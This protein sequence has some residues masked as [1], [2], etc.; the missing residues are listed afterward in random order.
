MKLT[1]VSPIPVLVGMEKSERG[2]Q[3][4]AAPWC[5]TGLQG[6]ARKDVANACAPQEEF[7]ASPLC[8]LNCHSPEE[9]VFSFSLLRTHEGIVS[10]IYMIQSVSTLT[11]G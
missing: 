9:L 3:A 7:C 2:L 11:G 6:W 10:H 5:H 8:V 1:E 4:P